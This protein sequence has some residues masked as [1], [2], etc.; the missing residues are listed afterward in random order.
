M[1]KAHIAVFFSFTWLWL[2]LVFC[3]EAQVSDIRYKNISTKQGLS[4]KNVFCLLQ[5][6]KGYVWFGTK[7]GL[8][9]YDGYSIRTYTKKEGLS[10][11]YVQ[12]IYEDREGFIWIGTFDGGLNRFD[13]KTGKFRI[14]KNDAQKPTSIS[15]NNIY[16]IFGDRQGVLWVG[17]FGGGLCRFDP[18]T[19]TF[20]TYQKEEGNPA[21]L[22]QN[23]VYSICEDAAGALWLGTYGG[24]L[25]RFDPATETFRTFLHDPINPNSLASDDVYCLYPDRAG[26]L[27][28]GTYGGGLSRLDPKT[29]EFRTYRHDPSAAHSLSS[30]YVSAIQEDAFGVL[31]IA[32]HKGGGLNRFDP[33]TEQ[34]TVFRNDT[35]QTENLGSNDLN[36][37]YLDR[38]GSLWIGTDGEGVSR[39]E[40]STLFF[41][42]FVS[43]PANP[44]GFAASSVNALYEDRQRTLWVGTNENGLY[45]YDSRKRAFTNYRHAEGKPNSLSGD[46]VTAICEDDQGFLWVGTTEAGLCRFDRQHNRFQTLG[47]DLYASSH[48]TSKDIETIFKDRQGQLWIGTYGGGLNVLN[49]LTGQLIVYQHNAKDSKS[50]GGDIVKVIYEDHSG[51]FWIGTKES[52]LSRFDPRTQTFT[53]YQSVRENPN[54]LASN[55]ITAIAEDNRGYL[56]I[57]TLDEGICRFDRR[58]QTFSRFGVKEGLPHNGI[59]GLLKDVRGKLWMSTGK[60]ISRLDPVSGRV[61]NYTT[62]DGLYNDEFV[63]WSYHQGGSGALYF[64]GTNN[65]VRFHP[66]EAIDN[67]YV[68]PVYL[69]TFN[70]FNSPRK[71]AQPLSETTVIE[72]EHD[73]NI[74]S[75][76]F[77]CLDY[78]DP[79]KNQYA[80]KMEGFDK[81]W[82]HIGN[83]RIANYTNL[84]ANEYVFRVKAAGPNG[85]WNET[86]ASIRVIIQPAWYMTWWFRIGAALVVVSASIAYSRHRIRQVERQKAALEEL[87]KLRTA[88]LTAQNEEIEAQRDSIEATNLVLNEAKRTIEDQ[89]KELKFSNNQ[90]EDRVAQRT[91]ELQEAYVKL[92]ESNQELDT[93]IYRASHDIRGPV[94]RLVGLCKVALMDVNDSKALEYLHLL[95]RTGDETNQ[96]LLRVL[97]IYDI[98]NAEVHPKGILLLSFIQA[99]T[100][101]LEQAYQNVRLELAISPEYTLGSDEIL[102]EIILQNVIGN[103]FKYSHRHEGSSV[104]IEALGDKAAR[105]V[106]IRVVDNGRGIP[107]EVSQKL[108]TMFF[109]GTVDASGA[110][111]GLYV[112]RLATEKL[113]GRIDFRS[114]QAGQTVFE[115]SLPNLVTDPA[116]KE[117]TNYES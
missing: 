25:C 44:A 41:T 50:L 11:D 62:E 79:E 67:A 100:D 91:Q 83:R 42:P 51:I 48:L 74:F 36:A 102:L 1:G 77:V 20:R 106:C 26:R 31:W 71:L 57:G 24:G 46:G 32:T 96:T 105:Q 81:D 13:R 65:F 40:T 54:S 108:F 66:E 3:A 10:S 2:G 37:L 30:N 19:E 104:R 56:W 12:A 55:A 47:K 99:V 70:L 18:A 5:D 75:F 78:V 8:N 117:I 112:S 85:V 23:E 61:K 59:C 52:G 89:N 101:P 95:D 64:G 38:S 17:T 53:N 87:V 86:G 63:Q 109:K 88:E 107:A 29:S 27:W 76:E 4:H 33:K 93:F 22:N 28:I 73:E 68:A 58:S 97:R 82:N 98:R 7:Q 6:S 14:Y 35:S 15:S 92:L 69:T 90:L 116:I 80:Y 113:G 84:D 49:P 103:A 111:L 115:I 114:G 43:N 34:F 9:L 94:A 110:G 45:Q 72:L 16:A 60:G 21:S 39:F